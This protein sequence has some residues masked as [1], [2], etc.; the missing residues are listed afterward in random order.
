MYETLVAFVDEIHHDNIGE[1]IIDRENN[2]TPE[3]PIQMPFVNY[4]RVVRQFE[5]EVYAFEEEHYEFGL[6]RY[7]EIL[8]KYNI[9]WETESMSMV[10]VSEMDGQGVMA[11]IMAAVR[12]E[13]FCD[14]ALKEFFENGSI[15]KWLRRLKEI[16]EGGMIPQ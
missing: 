15:E 16:D 1:W 3:H 2:G 6:N 11:L 4:S 7:G 12:A 13:R 14:G 10:D 9:D 5:R 8:E